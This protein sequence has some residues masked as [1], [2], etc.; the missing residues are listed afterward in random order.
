MADDPDIFRTRRLL[1]TNLELYYHSTPIDVNYME[2]NA[3]KPGIN[4]ITSYKGKFVPV[5]NT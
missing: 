2:L 4:H 1:T 3:L 5:H